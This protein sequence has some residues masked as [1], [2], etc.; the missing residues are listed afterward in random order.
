VKSGTAEVARNGV[1]TG[2]RVISIA[3][4]VPADNPQFA[5]IVVFGM[6][7]V[8]RSSVA[9]APAFAKLMEQTLKYYRVPPSSGKPLDLPSTW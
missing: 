7:Q 2:D 8:E 4:I 6:P 5:I 9:A 3:G 1:Y